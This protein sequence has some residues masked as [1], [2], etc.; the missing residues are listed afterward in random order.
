MVLKTRTRRI[1]LI[2]ALVLPMFASALLAYA[3]AAGEKTSSAESIRQEVEQQSFEE[4]MNAFQAGDYRR[5]EITF[6]MLSHGAQSPEINRKALFGLASVKLILA[7][8][9][10]EYE[11][12]VSTW[13]QWSRKVNSR[14]EGEDPRMITPFLLRME[15]AGRDKPPPKQ[16]RGGP[17]DIDLKGALQSKEK[18]TQSLKSKLELRE[19]EIRRLRHQL[20]SLEEIHR[21]YQEKKQEANP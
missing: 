6:D 3:W 8:T 9:L 21:K 7:R 17:R 5:A 14:M 19:R 12:A 20:E 2:F 16:N 10:D 4:A 13:E 11:E 18:E 15:P 1:Y